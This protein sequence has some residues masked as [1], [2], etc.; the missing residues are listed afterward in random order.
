MKSNTTTLIAVIVV[1]VIAIA[2]VGGYIVLKDDPQDTDP[3]VHSS[4]PIMGNA[5]GDDRI[6]QKDIDLIQKIIDDN[7]EYAAY[8]LADANNDG[9][10]DQADIDI[11][12]KLIKG[13]KT[14]AFV[15]DQNN[16]I[17]EVNYPLNNVVTINTDMLSLILQIGAEDKLAAYVSTSYPV[18]QKSA[19]DAGA[20]DFGK[21]RALSPTSYSDLIALDIELVDE[22]GV[23]AILAMTDA[24]VSTYAKDLDNA[25]IPVLKINCSAPI[26]SIDASLTIGFLLGSEIETKARAYYDASYNVLDTINEK[27]KDIAEEDKVKCLSLCMWAYVAEMESAYTQTSELAGGNNISEIAGDGS[28]KLTS[29]DAITIYDDAKYLVSYRTLDY[30]KDDIIDTW[31]STKNKPLHTSQAYDDGL[32]FVNAIMP[33]PCRIAYVAEV[34]YPE[35]FETGFG[36]KTLQSFVDEFMPYLNKNETDGV[37][38][39]TTDMTTIITKSMYDALKVE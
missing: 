35:I 6:D 37:F 13:E 19:D 29:A 1:A 23:G 22:G 34:F 16:D 24:A 9:K 25:G 33:V 3:V 28:S 18:S 27:L 31:D 8:P 17:I 26:D 7:L 10:I 12:K 21:G 4:L 11:T 36:D 32:I 39:V 14:A 5:N 30:V 2:A 20:K 38:D 15:R